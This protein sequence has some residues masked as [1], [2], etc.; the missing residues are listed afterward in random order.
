MDEDVDV[1]DDVGVDA[2]VAGALGV[3]E[4]VG[5]GKAPAHCTEERANQVPA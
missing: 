2:Y 4:G 5:S 3:Q 1:W